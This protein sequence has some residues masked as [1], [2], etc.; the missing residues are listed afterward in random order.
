[1][2]R[3]VAANPLSKPIGLQLYMVDAEL[4]KDFDGTLNRISQI[5][6]KEVEL[7]ATYGK[8]AAEWTAALNRAS[9]HCRSVSP[10]K[11]S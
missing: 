10:P 9:L 1:M 6:I 2:S 8:S 3:A 7:A 4:A 11:R 5:G